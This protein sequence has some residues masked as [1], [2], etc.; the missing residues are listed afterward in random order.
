MNA[1]VR[2]CFAAVA[3]VVAGAYYFNYASARASAVLMWEAAVRGVQVQGDAHSASFDQLAHGNEQIAREVQGLT[4][5]V[6]EHNRSTTIHALP[7]VASERSTSTVD[8]GPLTA[9]SANTKQI[10]SVATSN[11]P[12]STA[13]YTSTTDSLHEQCGCSRKKHALRVVL[14]SFQFKY[15]NHMNTGCHEGVLSHAMPYPK[16]EDRLYSLVA[17][18]FATYGP[19]KGREAQVFDIGANIGQ[20]IGNLDRDWQTPPLPRIKCFE[21]GREALPK[22]RAAAAN[23]KRMSSKISI[24]HKAVSN[25]LG[26]VSFDMG[27]G[28]SQNA[29]MI[30]GAVWVSPPCTQYLQQQ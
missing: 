12:S 30:P 10:Q 13:S 7:E 21:P 17:K 6:Q 15:K 5:K 18:Y 2:V 23:A 9:S 20:S 16:T 8:T 25:H 3:L 29:H 22:L 19:S 26:E 28:A 4:A 11:V 1:A 24:V 14:D 27:S